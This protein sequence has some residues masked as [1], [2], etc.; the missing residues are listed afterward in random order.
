[1]TSIAAPASATDW[2]EKLARHRVALGILALVAL[3]FV[4]PY[5]ALATNIVI[6]GLFT[7]GCNLLLG[8]T[9]LLSFGQAAFF[10]LGAYACGIAIVHG[11]LPVLP[12]IAVGVAGG[13]LGACVIGGMVIRSR[14]IYFA[15]VTLA[16]GQCVSAILYQA[17]GWTGG[18]NGLRGI[19][20]TSANFGLFK[21]DLINPTQ[22]FYFVVA[23]VVLA[24]VVV[25]RLLASPFGITLEAIRE[26]EKRATACGYDVQT[27]KWV[28]FVISGALCGLAGALYAI[29]LAI[30]PIDIVNYHNSGLAV[31]MALLGGINTFFGPFIGAAIFLM[32]EDVVSNYTSHWQLVVGTLFIVLI[33]FFP[34]GIWGSLVG[35]ARRRA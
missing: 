26:N 30:V 10:G 15:M 22:K 11:G 8:Y 32:L 31:M 5:E 19:A 24:L 9:G 34:R 6:Y 17:D 28:V 25:E 13:V 29:Q 33:L 4:A 20:A 21:V 23:F 3:R 2:F 1:M 27:T 35:L 12:A 7:L 14:G 16:L 18:E